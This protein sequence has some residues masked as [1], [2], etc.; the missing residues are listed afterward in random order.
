LTNRP[1]IVLF[2]DYGLEGPYIGQLEAVLH[3]QVPGTPV[4]K[5]FSDLAPFD[6]ESAACLLPA[7]TT[8][9]PAG[10]VFLCVV[11]PGVG[12]ARAG[13][14]VNADGRWFV[15]PNEG[16]FA[17]LARRADSVECRELPDPEP[18]LVSSSF[19]GR[20]VFAPV[21]AQLVRG[22]VSG[23]PVAASCLDRPDWPDDSF[24]I[25]YIDRFGNAMTGVRAAALDNT[26]TLTVNG[27]A[28]QSA[29]T[30]AD[31]PTGEAFWYEN[32]NGLVEIAVN[33]GRADEVLGLQVGTSFKV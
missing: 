9:F 24:R 7:Y 3:Q 31:V 33:Q 28:L 4:I 17:L 20:D 6:I 2:T 10:T 11:D 19:H 26:V 30:F 18:G 1:A 15:G 8:G 25:V 22:D 5:L 13:V 32:A 12:T 16:L 29:R 14:V 27:C 23:E 21:A